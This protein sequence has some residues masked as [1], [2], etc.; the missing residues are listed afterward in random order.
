MR[1]VAR[2]TLFKIVF[3]SQFNSVD[4][5]LV[6]KLFKE[7]KLNDQDKVYCK[8][9]FELITKNADYIRSVIDEKSIAFPEKRLFPADKSILTVALAEILYSEDVPDKV[10]VNEAANVASKYSSE[11]SASFISGI[12]SEVIKEKSGV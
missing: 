1:T 7:D 3:A 4:N 2:E 5:E 6:A 11:K 8:T 10:A 12:L 9:T